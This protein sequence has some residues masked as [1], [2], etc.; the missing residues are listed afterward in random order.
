[1]IL[2]DTSAWIEYDRETG[3]AT[4]V[5]LNEFIANEADLIVT[6]PVAMELLTGAVDERD[7]QRLGAML[8]YFQ[9]VPFRSPSDFHSATRIYRRCRGAGSTP[10]G[11]LD[12]MI[13]AV[14]IRAGAKILTADAGLARVA[15]ATGVELA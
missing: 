10:A 12:C 7:A 9:Q 8:G 13:V 15:R 14:A 6:D 2:A 11:M 5:A 1:M 4:D 3:S